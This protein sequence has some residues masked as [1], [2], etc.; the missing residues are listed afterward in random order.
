MYHN[1]NRAQRTEHIQIGL[2]DRVS[3]WDE[4]GPVVK[5]LVFP[6]KDQVAVNLKEL[7]SS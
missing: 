6:V 1:Y 2:S 7:E 3:A 5:F 4:E